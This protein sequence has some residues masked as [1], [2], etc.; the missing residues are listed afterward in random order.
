MRTAVLLV[1]IFGVGCVADFSTL[2]EPACTTDEEC[3][4]PPGASPCIDARCQDGTCTYGLRV[5]N[6]GNPC[7]SGSCNEDTD[8]C[9]FQDLPDGTECEANALCEA[10]TC[11]CIDGF[12]DCDDE[13]GCEAHLASDP[14]HCHRCD[15]ECEPGQ[16][17]INASCGTC[18][19]AGDCDDGKACSLDE[20][21]MDGTCQ[22]TLEDDA[23]LISG[24]CRTEREVNPAEQCQACLPSTSQTSW[25][26]RPDGEPCN[27]GDPCTIDDRCEGGECRGRPQTCCFPS[28]VDALSG[29]CRPPNATECVGPDGRC[30]VAALCACVG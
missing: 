28:C 5:C 24:Q 22:N 19:D 17:C 14:K 12:D 20:C 30:C 10:G 27:D 1:M 3:P 6:D 8:E 25:T 18:I 23:C 21:L 15:F 29:S 11:T 16:S 4:P 9:V 2:L 7:T 26:N 13:P